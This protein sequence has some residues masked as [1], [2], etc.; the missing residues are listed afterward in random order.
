MCE[1]QD[2]L[3]PQETFFFTSLSTN[4][5][6]M[7]GILYPIVYTIKRQLIADNDVF[8]KSFFLTGHSLLPESKYYQH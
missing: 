8:Y 5:Q 7:Q 4:T 3:G 6:P 2:F 1:G